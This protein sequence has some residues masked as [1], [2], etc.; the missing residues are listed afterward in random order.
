[1]INDTKNNLFFIEPKAK[2]IESDIND[3]LT[4]YADYLMNKMKPR[5][6]ITKGFHVC[7]CKQAHS[8]NVT[9]TVSIAGKSYITNSLLLH[10]IKNHRSEVPE[11]ELLIMKMGSLDFINKKKS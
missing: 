4:Q 9:Y 2:K 3:E 10:Y 11:R 1:M 8:S 6:D 5:N 7:N